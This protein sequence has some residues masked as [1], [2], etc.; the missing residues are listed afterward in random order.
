MILH[1]D[2]TWFYIIFEVFCDSINDVFF[3][4][5]QNYQRISVIFTK[6]A[7]LS[8]TLQVFLRLLKIHFIPN[9]GIE[10]VTFYEFYMILSEVVKMHIYV[11]L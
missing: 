7:G 2:F 10:E 5:R 4:K 8:N 6:G 1:D 9:S 11:L 3:K